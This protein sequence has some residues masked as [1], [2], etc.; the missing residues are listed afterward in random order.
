MGRSVGAPAQAVSAEAVQSARRRVDDSIEQRLAGALS[1]GPSTAPSK[2]AKIFS[3]ARSSARGTRHGREGRVRG[4]RRKHTQRRA[5]GGLLFPLS[6]VTFSPFVY[7]HV[8][9]CIRRRIHE[10]HEQL[11]T[12][13]ENVTEGAQT[14]QSGG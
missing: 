3:K 2:I 6:S 13:R 10:I 12:N 1:P 11:Y 8:Y 9:T 5:G 7:I 4:G 14:N